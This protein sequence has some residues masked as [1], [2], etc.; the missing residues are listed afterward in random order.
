MAKTSRFHPDLRIARFLP[1][2]LISPR[3]FRLV[4][5]LFRLAARFG[6][7]ASE[8]VRLE[9]GQRLHLHLP[10]NAVSVPTPALLWVHGGG[11]VIGDPRLEAKL[12][13]HLADTLGIIVAAPA[14][15]LA[16][17][18]PYPAALDDLAAAMTWLANRPEV[19]PARIAIGGDSAG[20]GLAACLA[21]RLC[22][23]EGPRPAF[24]LLHQPMLDE[25]TRARPDPDPAGLRIWSANANRFGWSAYL[26]DV[27][28]PVPATASA[29]RASDDD[30][31][32]LPPSWLGVGTADL[33]HDETV[34]F[35]LRLRAVGVEAGLVTVPGGFHSFTAFTARAPVSRAYLAQ[36]TAALAQ[37]LGL[38]AR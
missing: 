15:R 23:T 12:C 21:L 24:L 35:A 30:L 9:N 26:R 11:L 29:A 25:A 22:A 34:C 20:G 38:A 32:R 7:L 10:A 6:P 27:A 3:T 18:H 37:G 28:G 13:A 4:R 31:A 33:F 17:E 36:M 1:R 16:P 8:T 19:D 2:A 5:H 14:Y